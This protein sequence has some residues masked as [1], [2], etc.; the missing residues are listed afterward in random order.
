MV[1]MALKIKFKDTVHEKG[2]NDYMERS[3]VQDWDK[4]EHISK[5][6]ME[7]LQKKQETAEQNLRIKKLKSLFDLKSLNEWIINN[8]YEDELISFFVSKKLIEE[9]KVTVTMKK[10]L[11]NISLG[12]KNSGDFFADKLFQNFVTICGVANLKD[13]WVYNIML[14]HENKDE[15]HVHCST[16]DGN[17]W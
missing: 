2:F 3:K 14:Y 6:K 17:L 15:F 1:K 12:N 5:N 16:A 11:Y 13:I 4:E 8:L 10:D 7:L 9:L